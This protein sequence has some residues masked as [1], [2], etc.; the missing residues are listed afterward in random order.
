MFQLFGRK[1]KGLHVAP[2]HAPSQ[3]VVAGLWPGDPG[4]DCGS[5]PYGEFAGLPDQARQ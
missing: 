4:N 1:V 3:F 5:S 2:I